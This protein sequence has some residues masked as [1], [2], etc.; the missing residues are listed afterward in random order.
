[1][2]VTTLS[3]RDKITEQARKQRRRILLP[4]APVDARMLHAAAGVQQKGYATP[5]LLGEGAKIKALAAAEHVD[6]SKIEL[7]DTTADAKQ[8]DKLADEYRER[9]KKENLTADQAKDLISQPLFYAAML[10]GRGDADGMVAGAVNTT[11]DVLRAS[12]KCIGLQQGIKTVS[13]HF[14]MVVP[15]CPLGDHGVFIFADCA[16]MIEPTAEQ[17]VDIA[18]STADLAKGLLGIEPRVAMLSFST[19]GSAQHTSV[20][21]MR[22]AAQLLRAARPDL[23][24]DGELQADAAIIEGVAR[25]K[26]PD[27]PLGGNANVLIF[28]DLDAGN[29]CYK[30]VQRLAKADAIGPVLQGLAKPV[31]DL[32]RGCSVQDIEDVTA[33]T[34]AKANI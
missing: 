32:S 33:I 9:R 6:I 19:R 27:S 31:N 21:R 16:V 18:A 7:I 28:P 12:I 29:I 11:G 4:E 15:D 13:S 10:A 24:V 25:R 17:L 3:V 2:E 1:M 23:L 30:L 26:A 34:A 5:V 20:T 14:I 8:L 22:E